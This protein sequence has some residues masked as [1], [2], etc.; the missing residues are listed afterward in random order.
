MANK[1]LQ[2]LLEDVG[3]YVDQS[4]TLPTGDELTSR[5]NYL[6]RALEEWGNAYQWKQLRF[7][8]TITTV[9]VGNPS[10]ALP[11]TFKKFM[12]PLVDE[13][14]PVGESRE[15]YEVRAE[16]RF[17]KDAADKFVYVLGDPVRGFSAHI[18]PSQ[19]S[20]VAFS[21]DFQAYPSSMATLADVCVAPSPEFVAT[22]AIGYVLEARSDA[23][24][25]QVKAD[26]DTMLQR[27]IEEEATPSGGENNRVDDWMREEKFI[28]GE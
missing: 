16:D 23:R 26:A 10:L 9:D 1:T 12:S 3:A 14:K 8:D 4:L 19:A 24:F 13:S 20:G 7:T 15:W 6:N 27:M 11:S 22:R 18:N 28:L 17:R 21:Y 2:Q 25:P 5:V